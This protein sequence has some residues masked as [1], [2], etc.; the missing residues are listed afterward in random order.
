M[1]SILNIGQNV[2]NL[3]Y[4]VVYRVALKSY[5]NIGNQYKE[6]KMFTNVQLIRV[7]CE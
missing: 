3:F 5:C 4:F 7:H 2:S 6:Q 1:D